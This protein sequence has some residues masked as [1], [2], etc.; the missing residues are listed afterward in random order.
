[1]PP[2]SPG[3]QL[4]T[5]RLLL[6]RWRPGDLRRLTAICSDPEVMEY[7]PA[8]LSEAETMA[9]IERAEHCFDVRGY[10]LWALELGEGGELIGFVGLSPV[11]SEFPF[12]P[13]VEVGWRLA[14]GQW[15]RGLAA[16]GASAA[17][18]FAFERAGLPS[19]VSF[20]A[21][22]NLRSRRLMER[23]G[24]SRDPAEDFEHPLLPFG[25][26]LRA[27]VLYRLNA[28]SVL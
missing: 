4:S 20:T 3:P 27:H 6:R 14:R 23:L 16:E 28:G 7:F 19:L 2:M 11:A 12:A 15:G 24:M 13:A 17:V 21:A 18:A 10:G 22:G 26:R 8:P 5:P 1:M 9:L 25:H